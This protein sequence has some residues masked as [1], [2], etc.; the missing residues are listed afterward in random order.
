[1]GVAGL[2]G[3]AGCQAEAPLVSPPARPAAPVTEAPRP[4]GV[5]LESPGDEPRRLLRLAPAP[6]TTQSVRLSVTTRV[7]MR[8]GDRPSPSVAVPGLTMDLLLTVA[9]PVG[10]RIGDTV[11]GP[12]GPST[13]DTVVGTVRLGA[14]R[15]REAGGSE[16]PEL[17]GLIESSLANLVGS[18]GTWRRN[19]HNAGPAFL[20]EAPAQ[21]PAASRELLT[22]VNEALVH[23]S[24]DLPEE[25]VGPSAS[26][27]V[28]RD[29]GS[30]GTITR[31]HVRETRH[32]TLVRF[33]GERVV[34]DVV[35][36]ARQEDAGAPSIGVERA[37]ET[38]GRGTPTF[39]PSLPL[40][41]SASFSLEQRSEN[42][43]AGAP[44]GTP[45]ARL[46]TFTELTM[47]T[48]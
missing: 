43:M 32:V 14:A 26:W 39:A 38:G 23:L 4:S 15:A 31:A 17:V 44:A 45:A 37:S 3:L 40:P 25:A 22:T 19:L 13:A 24:S 41:V 8:I 9:G 6:G 29:E 36:G 11:E 7:E 34:L 16:P 12:V 28:V 27:T 1:M 2:S 33:D 5:T 10:P 35:L 20:L 47:E 18:R 46:V 42:R 30:G 48:R 21:A